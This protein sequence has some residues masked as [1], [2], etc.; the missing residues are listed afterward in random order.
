MMP[1]Q[2]INDAHQRSRIL[3]SAV[4]PFSVWTAHI[5]P[6]TAWI[7]ARAWLTILVGTW[8]HMPLTVFLTRAAP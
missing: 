1:S 4:W 2:T 5:Q 8:L 7:V 6:V 3:K